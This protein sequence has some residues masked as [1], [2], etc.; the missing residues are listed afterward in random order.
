MIKP[1]FF[2]FYFLWQNPILTKTFKHC[3]LVRPQ[4]HNCSLVHWV[5][6]SVN[7]THHL[8]LFWAV[9][10]KKTDSQTLPK[11]T[12]T[13]AADSKTHSWRFSHL[14]PTLSSILQ[15]WGQ[16]RESKHVAAQL[17]SSG[18]SPVSAFVS[19]TAASHQYLQRPSVPF[20]PRSLGQN[21]VT[22]VVKWSHFIC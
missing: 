5:S 14:R 22:V 11:G 3:V 17:G 7:I 15:V 4:V 10:S 6:A 13:T 2:L 16:A 20:C 18:V 21:V 9:T 1:L 12:V 8:K 19:S